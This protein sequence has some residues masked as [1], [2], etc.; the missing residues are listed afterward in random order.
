V[1]LHQ[2]S[3]VWTVKRLEPRQLKELKW[4]LVDLNDE[5]RRKEN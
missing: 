5:K 4:Q 1:L 3:G 2:P